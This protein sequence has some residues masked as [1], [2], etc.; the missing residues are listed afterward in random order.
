MFKRYAIIIYFF[1]S[2]FKHEN[3]TKKCHNYFSSGR[4]EKKK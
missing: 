2:F 4:K 3:K 1:L